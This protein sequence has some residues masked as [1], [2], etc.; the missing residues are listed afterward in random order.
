MDKG[1]YPTT[2]YLMGSHVENKDSYSYKADGIIEVKEG[3]FN[4]D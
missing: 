1:L 4:F 2:G 3:E